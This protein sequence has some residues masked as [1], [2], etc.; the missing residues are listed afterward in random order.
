[1]RVAS[2]DMTDTSSTCPSGLR[3]LTSPRR[4]CAMN[5][6]S[7]GCS[8]AVLP[9]QGVQYSQVCGKIIGYQHNTPDA[10]NHGG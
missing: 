3:T 6:G 1:M 10:Y 7:R 8:S 5:T 9:V 4:L 2:I